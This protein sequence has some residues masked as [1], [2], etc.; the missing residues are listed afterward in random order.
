[1]GAGAGAGVGRGGEG[2]TGLGAGSRGMSGHYKPP[3]GEKGPS[4]SQAPA[5][6]V[7][8]FACLAPQNCLIS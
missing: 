8:L 3:K 7:C 1:M 4:Q 6:F 2:R 5:V